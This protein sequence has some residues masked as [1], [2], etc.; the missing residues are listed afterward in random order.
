[1]ATSAPFRLLIGII[2]LAWLT[3][4]SLLK[5]QSIDSTLLEQRIDSIIQ[6]G[7]D[8]MAFP[9]A[10]VYISVAG[11]VILH[12]SYGHHTYERE[13]LVENHHLYDLASI[14]KVSTAL[15]I[16]MKLWGEGRFDLADQ[17]ADYLPSFKGSNKASLNFRDMLA[18]QA[19]LKLFS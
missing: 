2:L 4:T 16:L 7:I 18:H 8:S 6:L 5:A 15:P 10:Q 11:K 12:K 13:R 19:R 3:F 1:M 17:L 14:T 9:G